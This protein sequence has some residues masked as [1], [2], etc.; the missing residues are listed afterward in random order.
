MWSNNGHIALFY[1]TG[2]YNQRL[3]VFLL[4][5]NSPEG[6]TRMRNEYCS[7]VEKNAEIPIK[8]CSVKDKT[9]KNENIG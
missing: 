6:C 4:N 3:Y 8:K 9:A 2:K 5:K 7:I 1:L